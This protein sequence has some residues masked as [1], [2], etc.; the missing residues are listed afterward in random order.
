MYMSGAVG[1]L[2]KQ[3]PPAFACVVGAAPHLA[4]TPLPPMMASNT[5]SSWA[6]IVSYFPVFPPGPEKPSLVP[7]HVSAGLFHVSCKYPHNRPASYDRANIWHLLS[8]TV[9]EQFQT[10]QPARTRR[11]NSSVCRNPNFIPKLLATVLSAKPRS[12]FQRMKIHIG[13]QCVL[14]L[15]FVL[16]LFSISATLATVLL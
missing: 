16:F 7:V 12:L 3:L 10:G 9:C 5:P 11:Q 6:E 14:L 13:S 1:P 4:G 2:T 15:C 8:T